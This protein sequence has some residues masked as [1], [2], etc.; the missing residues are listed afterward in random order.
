MKINNDEIARMA[1]RLS[2]ESNEQQTVA[3]WRSPNH[4]HFPAWIDTIPAAA[5][6]GFFFGV[7]TDSHL[8]SDAPMVAMT[9]TVY[10]R[11]NDTA[12][13]L[14]TAQAIKLPQATPTAAP[15]KKR[16]TVAPNRNTAQPMV[17]DKIRYD[18][19]VMD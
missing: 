8:Q 18:L 3:P 2:N 9:D 12:T 10:I 15:T 1:Q 6:I 11:V 16:K 13:S 17:S 7:W 5:L 14:D 19:L 4:R